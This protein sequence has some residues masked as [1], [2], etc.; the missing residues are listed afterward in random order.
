MPIVWSGD[1]AYNAEGAPDGPTLFTAD[2]SVNRKYD[3]DKATHSGTT[4]LEQ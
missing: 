3:E 1:C 4:V 2:S